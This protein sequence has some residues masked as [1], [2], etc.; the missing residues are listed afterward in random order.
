LFG[1]G[2]VALRSFDILGI[3]PIR[4]R[5]RGTPHQP[6][7]FVVRGPY[8]WVRHPL[9]SAILILFWTNPLMTS[10]RLLFNVLW[11][12]W[13]IMGTVLE[14][15]DLV[16]EFGEVYTEYKRKVPMLIPWRHPAPEIS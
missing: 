15:R 7:P 2:V 11:T 14:E 3:G 9:Y 4:A 12:A 8:R 10:D 16:R 1:W 6:G 5:L 13:M